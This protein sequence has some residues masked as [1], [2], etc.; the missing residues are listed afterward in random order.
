MSLLQNLIPDP[1]TRNLWQCRPAAIS[2]ADFTVGGF[3]TPTSISCMKVIGTRIYG[4]VSTA[5]NIGH[6][7][8]FVYDIPSAAFVAITGVT[9]ANTPVSPTTSGAW[10]PPSLDLI[11][12]EIIVAHP[13]FTGL[14]GAFFGVLNILNA[15]APTWTAQNTTTNALVAPPQWVVNFNGRCFFLVNPTGAQP[16]AYMSDQLL[17]TSITNANQI[18]TFGDNV[19]LTCAAGLPLSNQ[20]GGIIQ[21][22][23]IFK[24]ASN[25]YQVT[26]DYSLTNLAVNTLNVATG[27]LAPNTIATSS[28]GLVFVA[29]DGVRVIDFEARVSDPIG[30]DGD[31]ITVPFIG[32]L[33]PSRMCAA[34][35][36]GLYRVQLQNGAAPGNPAQQWWY[37]FVRDLWSGPHTQEAALMEPYLGTFIATLQGAGAILFQSD[38]VQSSSSTYVENGSA[39]QYQFSTPM[40]PDTDEM[41]ELAMIETTIHMSLVTG[42]PVQVS[43]VD[44]NAAIIDS[45]NITAVGAGTLWGAFL[46]GAAL[47]QGAQNALYP[48]QLKWHFPI[49]FRRMGL[50]VQGACASGFKLGRM[51]LRYQIL[52]YL[53]QD[54]TGTGA[55]M[56]QSTIGTLTLTANATQTVVANSAVTPTSAIYLMPVTPDAANDMATTSITPGAGQFTITHANNARVDRTFTYTVF[57]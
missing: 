32:A 48:R 11:G 5:R 13:G 1:T 33:T 24:G 6:D 25:I 3:D 28:K 47:W 43:A 52:G 42:S 2:L 21:S 41:S 26:G 50:L 57:N 17:A 37:D 18:L 20:L 9:A 38:Q 40:L 54:A 30:K 53:Q 39:L 35:N 23:M 29:P 49:V 46:W 14:S 15:A 34:F 7:E 44:Q 45:V 4:M 19:P 10:V 51:H 36:V 8:P 16:A 22:L 12:A 27:T 56:G 55:F 31:G